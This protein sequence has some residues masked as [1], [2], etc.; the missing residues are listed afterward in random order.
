MADDFQTFLAICNVFPAA[1]YCNDIAWE[2]ANGD[3][4]NAFYLLPVQ[5]KLYLRNNPP[6]AG[7][8]VGLGGFQAGMFEDKGN[9]VSFFSCA[10]I[11]ENGGRKFLSCYSEQR[12]GRPHILATRNNS[13]AIAH[14][15]ETKGSSV[16]WQYL[17]CSWLTPYDA[18]NDDLKWLHQTCLKSVKRIDPKSGS[19]PWC[20]HI[21]E[22]SF[23][24]KNN[25]YLV[26]PINVPIQSLTR[27]EMGWVYS[28]IHE[29]PFTV[30]GWNCRDDYQSELGLSAALLCES[31]QGILPPSAR[32]RLAPGWN[33]GNWNEAGLI[34]CTPW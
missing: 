18:R 27:D 2:N 21:Y 22:P 13:D 11:Q 8:S 19:W 1:G 15:C 30:T 12:A 17:K 25:Y 26:P 16:Q 14:K 3:G 9:L 10:S 7:W 31:N 23:S 28:T 32:R 20:K 29:N 34:K 6:I 24:L 5:D 33:C 4:T